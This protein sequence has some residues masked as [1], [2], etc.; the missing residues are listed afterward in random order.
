VAIRLVREEQA[1]W[2]QFI[3]EAGIERE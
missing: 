1:R 2:G 3:R